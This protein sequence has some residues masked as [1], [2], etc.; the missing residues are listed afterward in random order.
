MKVLVS[1]AAMAGLS[2]AYWFARHGHDVTVVEQ[3]PRI[4]PGGAPID[5]RGAALG[6]AERMGI[7]G[8]IRAEQVPPPTPYDVVGPDGTT[9]ARFAIAWFGNE[10]PDDVEI[11]RDRL[12]AALR[13]AVG[14]GPRFV[15]DTEV[16]EIDQ[17]DTGVTATTTA[18]TE[19]YDLVIGAD[20]LHSAVRR[21]V[22]GEE[23]QFVHHLGLYV[24]L[25]SLDPARSWAPG[26]YNAPGRMACIRTD[27]DGPLG[28]VM[29]RSPR[30][31]YDFRDTAAQQRIVGDVLA[32][33]NAWQIPW[34]R[35][36]ILDPDRP[37]FYFDS[38]SQ[39]R[40]P[41]WH[42]G[43]VVLVGDAA[44]C[45][46]LL[47]GMGTSLAMT[48]AEFLAEAVARSPDDLAAAFA[49]YEAHQ[50]PLVNRAQ[51]GVD[52]NSGIMVPETAR[53]LDRRNALLREVAATAGGRATRS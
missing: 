45:A 5:V 37:A 46:A 20:G 32:T 26:M 19:R 13:D 1:G 49:G 3:A 16:T 6:T 53:E 17:D 12:G 31:T 35:E 18:S 41:A 38:I 24:A 43:R 51:A 39:T 40:M 28:M 29:F 50:R 15:F 10:C 27:A 33:D 47:S 22:F 25:V 30:L 9:R 23:Q 21:L 44:H 48:G 34:L 4:R 7:L 8:R 2:T 52:G 14:T 42:R 36:S 11:T